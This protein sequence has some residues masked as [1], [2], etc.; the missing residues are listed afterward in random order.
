MDNEMGIIERLQ[1][2]NFLELKFW[3]KLG[4]IYVRL[5]V[6]F[7]NYFICFAVSHWVYDSLNPIYV[8]GNCFIGVFLLGLAFI[9]LAAIA[10]S[11]RECC[12]GTDWNIDTI[13]G[14]WFEFLLFDL[15]IVAI[16]VT[17]IVF[18]A[19]NPSAYL[20]PDPNTLKYIII[21]VWALLEIPILTI[22]II[23]SF[24]ARVLNKRRFYDANQ[25]EHQPLLQP[26]AEN[27]D[28]PQVLI[29]EVSTVE[30]EDHAD[31]SICLQTLYQ[32]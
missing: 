19:V 16:L 9:P 2:R 20:I 7:I 12:Y 17:F 23:G 27:A 3:H 26:S 14:W 13:G 18:A 32:T 31:C 11:V 15:T 21:A 28:L 22:L 25:I 24:A 5:A 10:L 29:R 8:A 30:Q 6:I 4:H 1:Q